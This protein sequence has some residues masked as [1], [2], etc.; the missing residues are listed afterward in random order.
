MSTNPLLTLK[1]YGQ[2]LWMDYLSR[3]IIETGELKQRIDN[4]GL[5][6]ITSNPSIFEK[7][8]RSDDRYQPDIQQGI[9]N[10][11]TAEQIYQSLAFEDVRRACDELRP[12]YNATDG[13]D[14]YVSIEVSPHLARDIAGTMAEARRFFATVD[15]DNVMIKIP[16]TLEGLGAI[17]QAIT[18]GINVNV[19]LLF[20][21][22][23]YTQAAWA[24]IRGLEK[25]A[26]LGRPIDRIASVASFFL[27]RI[28]TKVD[29]R[30]AA[31]LEQADGERQQRLEALRG[32][33]AIANAKLAY[34][35]FQELFGSER[36]QAL[37]NRGA[38]VQRLLWAS[39]STK[40]PD[41]SDVMYVEELVGQHTINTMPLETIDAVADHG[42]IQPDQ[43]LTGWDLARQQI[44]SL[45]DPAIDINLN[46]VMDELLEEGIDKFVKPYDALLQSIQEKME[47]L[48]PA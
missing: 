30:L 9:Q 45:A 25:R 43:V 1:E 19:T 5:A 46:Q 40:N 41:Y 2:S 14:G 35:R 11:W 31:K 12:V 26:E 8:I 39:T 36:W 21:V 6:G 24:Y 29:D 38:Q 28:D 20:S 17:E 32:R 13:A 37:A 16:G 15:R 18:E 3:S 22:E 4:Q 34:Q 44:E 10:E 23:M 48:T 33:I 27:S 42:N 47:Q 7:S